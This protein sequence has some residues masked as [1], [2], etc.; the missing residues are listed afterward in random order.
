MATIKLL[1]ERDYQITD[2]ISV[3]IPT[4]GEILKDEEGY[5]DLV[6][7]F[8][9]M[10]VDMM[11]PLEDAGIDFAKISAFELFLRLF[12]GIQ[13]KDTSLLFGDLDLEKFQFAMNEK[14]GK[15]VLLDSQNDIVIDHAIHGQIAATL[16]R[17][18]HLEKNNRKP[19]NKDGRDYLLQ[20][21]R[22]KAARRKGRA[23][24]SQLEPLIIALVNTE[25]F[26]YDFESVK[27]LSI[28]Q[29]NESVRQVVNKIDYDNRMHG[30]YSGTVDVKKLGPDELSWIT[31]K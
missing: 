24:E 25:Q 22:E 14:T 30:I 17:I 3:R 13:H 29:F 4:V 9:S 27:D 31:H 2:K 28:Y 15:V 1:Y 26:K 16:R 18:H 5:Y 6:Y 20:R 10:P 11:L 12:G 19:G 23:Q 7:A 8:T 21:A